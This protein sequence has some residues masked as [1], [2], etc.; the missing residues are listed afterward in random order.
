[1]STKHPII[2]VTGSSGAGTTTVSTTFSQ[3][4]RREGVNA[5]MVEGDAF[6]RYDRSSMREAMA[7]MQQAGHT[8][9]SH[10]G[11]EANLFEELEALFCS[12]G[13]TGRGRILCMTQRRQ[14]HSAGSQA[15]S[16]RGRICCLALIC[17]STRACMVA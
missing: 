2:A 3:I 15:R 9:F 8:H 14:G 10:F 11:P 12:Y 7:E 16:P 17:C 1:M 13:E 5:A 6:H 4:F